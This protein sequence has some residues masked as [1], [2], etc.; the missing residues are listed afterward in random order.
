MCGTT[1]VKA[2]SSPPGKAPGLGWG[3]TILFALFA[4]VVFVLASGVSWGFFYYPMD[5]SHPIRMQVDSLLQGHWALSPQITEMGFDLAWNQGVHQLWG[6][7]VALWYLPFVG[8]GR[9]LGGLCPDIIPLM[10][11]LFLLSLYALRTMSMIIRQGATLSQGLLFGFLIL[12][13]PALLNFLSGAKLIYEVTCLYALLFCLFLLLATIRYIVAGKQGDFL[14]AC[15][16]S[17][18]VAIIRP[19]YGVYGIAAGGVLIWCALTPWRRRRSLRNLLLPL[20]GSF[21]VL[22]GFLFLAWSNWI[23]FGSP[24]EFGHNLSFSSQNIVYLTRFGN[25]C[26]EASFWALVR[27]LFYWLFIPWAIPVGEAPIPRWRDIYQTTFDP[28]YLLIMLGVLWLLWH[29]LLKPAPVHKKEN[30]NEWS[31][32]LVWSLAFWFCLSVVALGCFY[33]RFATLSTRYILDFAPAFLAVSLIPLF[34]PLSQRWKTYLVRGLYGWMLLQILWTQGAYPLWKPGEAFKRQWQNTPHN[35]GYN[36][37]LNNKNLA[38]YQ[39]IYSQENHPGP[40]GIMGNGMGWNKETGLVSAVAILTVDRPQF[41]EL[42]LG[43]EAEGFPE[44]YRAKIN[45]IELPIIGIT[46]TTYG[47]NT[48]KCVRF[49]IPESILRQNGDQLISLCFTPS[50]HG[51]DMKRTRSLYQARWR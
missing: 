39:G 12:F 42:T 36:I 15:F 6:V 28:S 45:T 26:D 29:N 14:L 32:L 43:P 22:A 10:V 30:S 46:P 47:T 35:F 7:G 49:S 4:E 50:F 13:C 11:A 48:A 18:F 2:G 24:F 1:Q 25:P 5:G 19:T 34:V 8:L 9:L 20:S 51:R 41:L 27:E 17:G 40:T 3:K 38:D 21:L 31:H 16:L 44:V 37:I 33:I 23:R